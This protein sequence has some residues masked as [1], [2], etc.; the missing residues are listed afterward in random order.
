MSN[1]SRA[2]WTVLLA[3]TLP[4]C[5][6]RAQEDTPGLPP[7][8]FVM[9]PKKEGPTVRYVVQEMTGEGAV[10]GK[11]AKVQVKVKVSVL[12]PKKGKGGAQITDD[13]P[14]LI[15][16]PLFTTNASV[17]SVQVTSPSKEAPGY[18]LRDEK[19]VRFVASEPGDYDIEM[20][21]V[22][23]VVEEERQRSLTLPLV[24][25]A[26]STLKLTV[27]DREI[28]VTAKP[29]L[30]LE[31]AESETDTLVTI[32]GGA[33]PEV[34][35]AWTR[36][37]PDKKLE[38][39]V[40]A[41]Q[42]TLVEITRGACRVDSSIGYAILQSSVDELKVGLPADCTLLN[43]D[44]DDIRSW[45]VVD[46][47]GKKA[48][49]VNLLNPAK[50]KYELRLQLEKVIPQIPATIPVPQIDVLNVE[51]EKGTVAIAAAKGVQVEATETKEVVQIDVKETPEQL[52]KM[53]QSG[54]HLCFRYLRKPFT[55]S[56]KADEIAA[57]VFAEFQTAAHVGLTSMRMQ[58]IINYMIRDAGVFHFKVGLGPDTKLVA[59]DG[60]NINTWEFDDQQHVLSIDMRSK[61]EDAY[62][63]SIELERELKAQAP[64]REG[65]RLVA[66][67]E[68]PSIQALDVDRQ[69]GYLV[70]SA[71]PG[72][73]VEPAITDSASQV[74]VRELPEALRP[75][76]EEVAIA[77]RYI[78][79]G[80]RVSVNVSEVQPEVTTEVAHLV[81]VEEKI[82]LI[83]TEI[84]YKI[85][86]AGIFQLR[87]QVPKALRRRPAEG[88]NIDDETYDETKEVLTINLKSKVEEAYKLTLR[89]EMELDEELTEDIEKTKDLVIPTVQPIDV[90]KERGHIGVQ[91]KTTVRLKKK[92]DEVKGLR[93]I[94]IR[95]LPA[96]LIKKAPKLSL[97]FQYFE[98]GWQLQLQAEPIKPR[99]TVETF[100][101]V[102]LGEDLMAVSASAKF[103][104]LHAG[105][106]EF[107]VQM[108]PGATNVDIQGEE[109]K[110]KDEAKKDGDTSKPDVRK[111]TLH[112]KKQGTYDLYFTFEIKL[113]KDKGPFEYNGIK[114]KDHMK[115]VERET[116]YLAVAAR[117]DVEVSLPE[118]KPYE[119]LTPI[120]EKE[121]PA[122]YREGI[123]LPILLSFRYLSHPI[124][125][126]LNVKRHA[127][128][129][130][131]VAVIESAKLDTVV[132]EEGETIT[133][134]VADVRNSR[135]QY[136]TLQ[137]PEGA[138][139][140]HAFVGGESVR[141]LT[142]TVGVDEVT[143]LPIAQVGK[144]DESFQVRLRY[145]VQGEELGSMGHVSLDFPAV[146]L[147]IMR[148]GWILKLPEGYD[149]L[150]DRG[151]LKRIESD[152]EFEPR[153][154]DLQ[155]DAASPRRAA[156]QV[157]A[158]SENAPNF[159]NWS[160]N[161][162]AIIN[163]QQAQSEQG[164]GGQQLATRSIYTGS[165][166]DLP[167]RFLFQGLIIPTDRY[168]TIRSQ[169]MKESMGLPTGIGA[170]IVLAAVLGWLWKKLALPFL[171]KVGL[172]L[173]LALVF[174]GIRTMA[175][176][177][178]AAQ[179]AWIIRTIVLVVVIAAI[180][181]FVKWIKARAASSAEAGL[182]V[183]EAA[184]APSGEDE[185][186]G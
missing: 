160:A 2:T 84:A 91:T 24:V 89:N 12:D 54:I 168:V 154:R 98:P 144:E 75:K 77:Y 100:N 45:D 34:E 175:E 22:A 41:E 70:V 72:M 123:T 19:G 169:Y 74:D 69:R 107:A 173:I 112:A 67:A 23:P 59:V 50:E 88:E 101:F 29:V 79:E 40:F 179:L 66:N 61:A 161:Q 141:P 32:Y 171:P 1:L 62:V 138:R 94:D 5:M 57:K 64:G 111:V 47:A 167:N 3:L 38:A 153:L 42:N 166:P 16:A 132:T 130:V 124:G 31:T 136:L 106:A 148:L 83:E 104:I 18:V 180:A 13:E 25:A 105:I 92:P 137:L 102:S 131:V 10:V 119:N 116:G 27:P 174:L 95:D 87:V 152:Y 96:E 113:D 85:R 49:V 52:Q 11:L 145:S 129:E 7:V 114:V 127:S 4:P 71:L 90:E 26:T 8:P 44:G 9:Q 108:P 163:V 125:V 156:S 60:E 151:T 48:L 176:G 97:A 172:Y 33:V 6:T 36:K 128:A 55:I 115:E 82:V 184:D 93:D 35:L 99:V 186:Q 14:R 73:K 164:G 30:G 135:E 39:V 110:H 109:I 165:K 86:K 157:R 17:A 177:A 53:G 143:K 51:R 58:T 20:Q 68:V 78:K 46:E 37:A 181:A 121:I 126:K 158:L 185:E 63:L 81:T 178:Y 122:A 76:G 159:R 147:A 103:T 21:V 134:L 155:V 133:D 117:E 139:I 65:V 80:Y 56:I 170:L 28:E 15:E 120:D 162:K 43:V 140:W 146:N 149:L 150:W 118:V 182:S 183:D 142:E